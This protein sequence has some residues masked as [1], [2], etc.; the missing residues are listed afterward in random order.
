MIVSALVCFAVAAFAETIT[1]RVV[2]IADGGTVTVLD[3]AKVMH[4]IRLAGIDA[5]EKAQWDESRPDSAGLD[6]ADTT[7]LR[8]REGRSRGKALSQIKKLLGF[9]GARSFPIDCR[10]PEIPNRTMYLNHTKV[11]AVEIF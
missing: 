3:A 2:G 6:P 10:P 4:E 9:F 11:G 7:V 1:G 5:P 8:P